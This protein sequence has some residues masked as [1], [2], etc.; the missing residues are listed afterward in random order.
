MLS[1]ITLMFAVLTVLCASAFTLGGAASTGQG[2]KSGIPPEHPVQLAQRFHEDLG[3]SPEQVAKL[4]QVKEALTKEFTPLRAQAESLEHR[5]QELKLS[6]KPDEV[7]AKKLQHE[8][9]ELGGKLKPLFDRYANSVA[10]MLTPEQREKLMRLSEAHGK[11]H[12][13]SGFPLMFAMQS[14]EELGLSPQ[15]FTKLQYLQADFIRAFAPLREQMELLQIEIHD[16]FAATGTEPT[17]EFR[18]RGESIGR[19]VKELQAQ[20]SERAVKEVLLPNQRAKL[21]ELLGGEHR[22]EQNGR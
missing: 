1:R 17:Q 20:Y 12:D 2:D 4:I 19:K 18:D 16:K 7:A 14:R 8:S 10:E 5:M 21:G 15:Q 11:G 9:E 13:E 3:L 6:E 22:A